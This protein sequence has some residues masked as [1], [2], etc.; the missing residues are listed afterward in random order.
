[1]N[2]V[3]SILAEHDNLVLRSAVMKAELEQALDEVKEYKQAVEEVNEIRRR[4]G[5]EGEAERALTVKCELE[6]IIQ[7]LSDQIGDKEMQ[8]DTMREVNRKLAAEIRDLKK[9]KEGEG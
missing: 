5:W 6:R 9:N 1:M 7:G 3:E 8:I 4:Q 2:E